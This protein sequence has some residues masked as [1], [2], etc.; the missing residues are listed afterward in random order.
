MGA[1]V[2]ENKQE[3]EK[4]N[5]G[6]DKPVEEQAKDVAVEQTTGDANKTEEPEKQQFTELQ[7]PPTKTFQSKNSQQQQQLSDSIRKA[8]EVSEALHQQS[9]GEEN[10]A[11]MTDVTKENKEDV[12]VDETVDKQENTDEMKDITPTEQ[13]EETDQKQ[14][15]I[16]EEVA[17][18]PKPK[19]SVE[20]L[21]DLLD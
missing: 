6:D 12:K 10:K 9:K 5:E 3:P 4:K 1:E 16:Q 17:E 21:T 15:E 19:T 11:E 18:E 20:L 7:K 13:K 8:E 14:E 2:V